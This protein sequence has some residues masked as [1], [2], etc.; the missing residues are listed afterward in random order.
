MYR[1]EISNRQNFLEIENDEFE[2]IVEHALKH[3]G[4]SSAEISVAFVDNEEIHRLN[5]EFL[6]HDYATDVLSF[7][8]SVEV[9]DEV[10]QP[11]IEGEIVVSTEIAQEVAEEYGW[12]AKN[13]TILYLVHGLLHLAGYDDQTDIQKEEM[14]QTEREILAYWDIVPPKKTSIHSSSEI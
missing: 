1:I 12:S 9:D 5:R 11:T 13:E 2:R 6:K 4:F 8:Y 3:E 7:L 10:E 14:R